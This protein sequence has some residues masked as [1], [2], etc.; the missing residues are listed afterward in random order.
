MDIMLPGSSSLHFLSNYKIIDD[1]I[2]QKLA[3]N[4]IIKMLCPLD[5]ESTRIMKQLAPFIGYRSVKLALPKTSV[6][7]SFFVRDKHDII[8]F[9]ID[10]QKRRNNTEY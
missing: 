3:K 5:E 4:I 10:T 2:S 1:I 8:S 7:S 9:S 6:G